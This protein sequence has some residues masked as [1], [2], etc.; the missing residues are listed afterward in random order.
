MILTLRELN[1]CLIACKERNA[2]P[3]LRTDLESTIKFM[4]DQKPIMQS[5]D[6]PEDK[7]IVRSVK[8]ISALYR[9]LKQTDKRK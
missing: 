2:L 4:L 7:P 3:N 5:I 6:F 8:E 9:E 1:E